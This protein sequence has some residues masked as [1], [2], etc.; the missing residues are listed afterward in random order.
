MR[1]AV[2]FGAIGVVILLLAAPALAQ[3]RAGV[4][5]DLIRDV[6]EVQKKM[7]ALAN[8][9]PE[10][11]YAWKPSPP[12]RSTGE[13]LMHVAADNYFMPAVVGTKVPA[14]TGIDARNYDTAAAFEKKRLTRDQIIAELGKSFALLRSSMAGFPDEKLD[15]SIEAFGDRMTNR[16]LWVSTVTHLH[17][18][19]GQLIAY[20]RSNN[21]TPPWSK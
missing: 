12:V 14:E 20:A 3:E 11:T 4:M 13:V 1:S 17:E 10:A 6:D 19:L 8:A 16:A 5:G 2:Q 15:A 9:M 7:V 21:V 18:H